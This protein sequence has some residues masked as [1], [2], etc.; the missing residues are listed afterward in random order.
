M[1]DDHTHKINVLQNQQK[2]VK[3]NVS[4][5]LTEEDKKWLIDLLRLLKGFERRC[6]ELLRK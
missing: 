2:P 1:I 4:E 5:I 3:V 6:Q